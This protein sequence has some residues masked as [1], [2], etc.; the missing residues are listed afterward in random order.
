[1]AAALELN[2][3]LLYVRDLERSVEFYESLG[4]RL[5]ELAQGHYAW[6]A[7]VGG[8][9]RLTLHEATQKHRPGGTGI[10]LYFEAADLE[11]VCERLCRDGVE[12]SPPR[13]MGWGWTHSYLRDPDG[14]EL[15]LYTVDNRRR[16]LPARN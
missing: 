7:C 11:S 6:L 1:M 16:P 14:Y 10:R 4:L 5:S 12:L 15:S 2:H 3:A 8:A 9:S 13:R